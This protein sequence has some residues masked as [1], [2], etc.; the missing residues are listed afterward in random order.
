MAEPRNDYDAT[1]KGFQAVETLYHA[2][3]TGLILTVVTRRNRDDAA[4]L[5]FRVFRRQHLTKFLPGLEKLGLRR[6]PHAVAAA[7]Y[8]YLANKL[9]GVKVEY[10]YESDRKAWVRF[11]P[12]RWIFDGTAICGAP[13]ELS[14]AMLRAWYAH[15]GVSLGNPRLGFVCTKQ[16]TDGQSGL[17]GYFYEYDHDLSPD[18][19]LCFAPGEDGPEFDPAA[20][21]RVSTAEWPPERLQKVLRNYAMEYIRS[22]LPEMM[23]LFGPAEGRHLAGVA[24]KLIGMQYY[25]QTATLLGISGS[26]PE[27]F[28][29]YLVRIGRAQGDQIVWEEQGADL[30]VRQT[31]WRIMEGS[32]P[33][34]SE[35][36]DAW[37]CLW[38]G[39]LAVHNRRL[40]LQLT[41]R[42]D[43]GDDCFEWRL[44][45][46]GSSKLA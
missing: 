41:R 21:P 10:M 12:P 34:P 35:A 37:A 13:G 27:A 20:A 31:T 1:V 45:T 3:L 44:C 2:Y 22:M 14:R 38:E 18:E 8:H 23:N 36:F 26:E 16:T 24:G 11:V 4:E 46:K 30:V 43:C 40:R 28:A 5:L 42:L 15:N 6:L 29:E 25:D 32:G 33:L 39:A 7:Q 17:E 19:R 9:G